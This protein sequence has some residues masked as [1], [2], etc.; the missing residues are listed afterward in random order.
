MRILL[1]EDDQS[2]A[3]EIVKALRAEGMAVEHA[4]TTK[5]AL[6]MLPV[7]APELLIL[8]LG[9]PD[10][11]GIDVLKHLR[12]SKYSLPILVLTARDD[13]LSKVN[14]LDLGADDYL[15]KP[16]EL[17]ELLARIRAVTRRGGQ[18]SSSVLTHKNVSLDLASHSLTVNE[19]L[20]MLNRREFALLREM[21]ESIGRVKTRE[22]LENA[23]YSWDDDVASNTIEVHVSHLR[24]KLPPDFIK[25]IRGVGYIIPH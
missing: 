24:R 14:A 19:Q 1:L 16:F 22:A 21:M 25:T 8:D 7:Q 10:M 12:A 20:S 13:T 4:A 5:A 23:I 3:N 18:Q 17:I 11:D 6:D 9:L 15:A 2:I